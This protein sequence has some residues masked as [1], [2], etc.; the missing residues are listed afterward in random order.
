MRGVKKKFFNFA[1]FCK[2][3]KNGFEKFAEQRIK[4]H[5]H[6]QKTNDIPTQ[7]LKTI[8]EFKKNLK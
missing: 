1:I 4:T 3:R 2:M 7:Q 6:T 8:K 5:T